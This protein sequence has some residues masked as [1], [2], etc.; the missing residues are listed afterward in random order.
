MKGI[1]LS[2][3]QVYAGMLLGAISWIVDKEGYTTRE[4]TEGLLEGVVEAAQK[5]PV[6]ALVNLRQ[7]SES[8]DKFI[9]KCDGL[10]TH[11]ID[12]ESPS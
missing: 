7:F 11:S 4:V 8:V 1:L 5:K 2:K 6:K 10:E 9:E 3:K 12:E